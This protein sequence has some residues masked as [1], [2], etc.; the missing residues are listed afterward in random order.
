[1]VP[2][3]TYGLA[4][5]CPKL[6]TDLTIIAPPYASRRASCAPE[7]GTLRKGGHIFTCGLNI[8]FLQVPALSIV[9]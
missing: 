5:R 6:R 7:N 1:M 8:H 9:Y 2:G 4:S 3:T